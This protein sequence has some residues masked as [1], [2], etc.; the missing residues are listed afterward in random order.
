[1]MEHLTFFGFTK[2]T[3]EEVFLMSK[4]LF[5]EQPLVVDRKL[6][7]VIDLMKL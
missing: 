1:M 5:D 3:K 7:K 4:L 6:A 2:K